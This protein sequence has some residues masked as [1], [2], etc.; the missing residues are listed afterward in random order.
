MDWRPEDP[1]ET[2][3]LACS[4]L[5]TTIDLGDHHDDNDYGDTRFIHF[6]HCSVK[7]FLTSERLAGSKE[8][9]LSQYYI[10]P[11]SAHTTLAQSCIGTLLQLDNHTENIVRRFPLAKYAAQ[12]WFHHV[13]CDDVESRVENGMDRL[14]DPDRTHFAVWVSIHDTDH[15]SS[16]APLSEP[17]PPKAS[18][19]YYATL[20]GFLRL[21]KYLVI[22]RRQDPNKSPGGLCSSLHAAAFLGRTAIARFL[23]E[24]TADVNVWDKYHPTPLHK[25]VERGNLDVTQL[26]LGY[27]A[28]VNVL[29]HSGVSPLH[30]T[31]HLDIKTLTL[32]SFW[33]RAVRT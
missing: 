2:V 6:S 3:L 12:Y 18:P 14:F 19:L 31:R 27:G 30:C 16:D 25:V 22:T 4:N 32:Q 1:D 7:D 26:L 21:V 24:H 5:V 8:K 29:D 28:D 11:E 9:N 33:S 17:I 13:Q 20:F 10:S 15:V 23:L